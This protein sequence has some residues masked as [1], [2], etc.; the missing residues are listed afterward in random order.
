MFTGFV[1]IFYLSNCQRWEYIC[2]AIVNSGFLKISFE[3]LKN[4]GSIP[5]AFLSILF[6]QM[7]VEIMCPNLHSGTALIKIQT[8]S[9]RIRAIQRIYSSLQSC[10]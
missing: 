9:N 5:Y 6:L 10:L 8:V 2:H 1:A 7:L 4:S 3:F